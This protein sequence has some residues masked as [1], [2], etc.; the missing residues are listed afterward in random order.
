MAHVQCTPQCTGM[1]MRST[2]R[3][4]GET[5]LALLSLTGAVQRRTLE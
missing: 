4:L 3:M 1:M 2:S 5:W